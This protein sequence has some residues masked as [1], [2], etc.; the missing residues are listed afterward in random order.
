MGG[1]VR[2]GGEEGRGGGWNGCKAESWREEVESAHLV[3]GHACLC[4]C[5]VRRGLMWGDRAWTVMHPFAM[6][7]GLCGLVR[8]STWRESL[9]FVSFD[10]FTH[11]H[12]SL[13][14]V[15]LSGA[16]C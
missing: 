2:A 12:V 15:M 5:V 1:S 9:L 7:V 8:F 16:T 3:S 4:R 6:C 11:L 13:C 10:L 14:C